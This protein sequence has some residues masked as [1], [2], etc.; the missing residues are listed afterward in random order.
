M[1]TLLKQPVFVVEQRGKASELDVGSEIRDAD[2]STIGAIRPVE[3]SAARKA[4]RLV[5][6]IDAYLGHTFE[7]TDRT[8][9][10]QLRLDR[11]ARF[12][13]SRLVVTEPSGREIGEIT[14]LNSHGK[15]RFGLT[16]TGKPIGELRGR[17]IRGSSFDILDREEN[18][19]GRVRKEFEDPNERDG[20]RSVMLDSEVAGPL[21]TLAIAAGIA[22]DL[23]LH[24]SGAE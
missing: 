4:F 18:Q 22:L 15:I 8:G 2:G 1:S 9:T 17:S 16:Y 13:R 21:R 12:V 24:P 6:R 10:V 20:S 7:V 3:Q 11:P 14:Q 5:A 23:A 19:V